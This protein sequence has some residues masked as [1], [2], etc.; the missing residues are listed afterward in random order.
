ME[1]IKE[2][3]DDLYLHFAVKASFLKSKEKPSQVYVNILKKDSVKN[4]PVSKHS[5][6]NEKKDQYEIT[7]DIKKDFEHLNGNYL[8]EII[9]ADINS[10]KPD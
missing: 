9:V 4:I 3:H 2:A 1:G 10:Y 6:Y 8:I 5:V 7:L